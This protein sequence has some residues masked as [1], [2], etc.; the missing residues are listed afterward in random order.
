MIHRTCH[1]ILTSLWRAK[2]KI[3][4]ISAFCCVQNCA[5]L[6]HKTQWG[7]SYFADRRIMGSPNEASRPSS[8]KSRRHVLFI[9]DNIEHTHYRMRLI[10]T[11]NST[12]HTTKSWCH[13]NVMI[14]NCVQRAAR[15][16]SVIWATSVEPQRIHLHYICICCSVDWHR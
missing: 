13:H 11:P 2:I 8:Y 3:I 1:I 9:F 10:C 12:D 6:C 4:W 5:L 7:H 14:A 16:Y 15:T